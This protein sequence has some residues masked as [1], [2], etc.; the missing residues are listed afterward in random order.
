MGLPC[1]I[2]DWLVGFS[3]Q[4]LIPRFGWLVAEG[5]LLVVQARAFKG[6]D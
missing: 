1:I 4:P 3:A 2:G 6:E 5:V